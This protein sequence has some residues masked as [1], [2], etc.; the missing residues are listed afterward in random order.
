MFPFFGNDDDEAVTPR[1]LG[2]VSDDEQ[3]NPAAEL[4]QGATDLSAAEHCSIRASWEN[5]VKEITEGAGITCP[6]F[7]DGSVWSF[8]ALGAIWGSDGWL[9]D[10]V[11]PA[12]R[13]RASASSD[14]QVLPRV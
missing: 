12:L 5:K 7:A 3:K 9:R 11:L 10:V 13:D 14:S 1:R 6:D 4:P 8:D 2:D